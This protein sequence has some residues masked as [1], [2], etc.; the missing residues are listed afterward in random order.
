MILCAVFYTDVIYKMAKMQ[1][2]AEKSSMFKGLG[3]ALTAKIYLDQDGIFKNAMQNLYLFI[4]LLTMGI[5]SRE[6]NTGSI[7]LLYS[8]PIKTRDIV[9]GKY[10]SLMLFNLILVSVIGIFMVVGLFSVKSV[11]V[12][13]LLSA[14]LGFYLLVC[15]YAA[16]G[17]F[18]SSLTTY[19]IVSAIGTFII[20]FILSRIGNLWQEF[21]FVRDLTYF[22]SIN[23]RA[24]K[25][26]AGLITSKDVIYFLIVIGMF[27]GFTLIKLKSGRESG[28][29]FVTAGKYLAV[30]GIALCI[31]YF[32]SRPQMVGYWDTTMAQSN[33]IHPRVQEI[34]KGMGDDE[35]EITL[36]TN[37]FPRNV[38]HGLPKN[39]NIYLS[40]LWE[41][42]LRFKPDIKFKYEYYYA[43]NKDERNYSKSPDKSI[44]EKAKDQAKSRDLD[45]SMFKTPEQMRKIID[46]EPEDYNLVMQLKY[47]GR[48]TFLRTYNDSRVWP[49]EQ[50]IAAALARVQGQKMP[51][52]LFTTGNLERDIYV[53]GE[54]GFYGSTVGKL[55]RTSLI[56]NGFDI[57]TIS[58]DH[59]AVP[60]NYMDVAALVLADPKTKLS[61]LTIQR[62]N[63]Y[64]GA[65][66]NMMILGEP[67]KGE[68]LRP[69]LQPLG[70]QLSS[71]MLVQV[72]KNN[73]PDKVV[74]HLTKF[75]G[76]M[77]EE[78]AL[79][80]FKKGKINQLQSYSES[81]LPI[82]IIDSKNDFIKHP[83]TITD[84][85]AV[86]L[87]KGTLVKDSV[88]PVFS[89]N[90]GDIK[91]DSFVTTMALTRPIKGKEQRVF[92]AG[93]ADFLSNRY[94]GGQFF[95]RAIY[96]W[97]D[98]NKYP[99]YGPVEPPKDDEMLIGPDIART[100]KIFFVWILPV[101]LGLLGTIILIRRKRK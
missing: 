94:N 38:Q 56:N 8:A 22:L 11:D 88:P 44:E 71:G 33:T 95:G 19:Q 91:L 20:I 36:Y 5:L 92:V 76:G 47:K 73:T 26:L 50:H 58:L 86:W 49:E 65:G 27:L 93:D 7:K 21:D 62:I 79:V 39:R 77:A 60:T 46:L 53:S 45:L 37:L 17:L 80:M 69:M 24:N 96:S 68:V 43:L 101:V 66:G 55:E 3:S 64:I 70:V 89:P 28:R 52:V 12:G 4:P 34:I 23:G 75:A 82:E 9:L 10:L 29:W 90:E 2:L 51:T 41:P 78:D 54:R 14:A 98:N 84:S 97:L 87:K 57:D 63:E 81:V 30:I 31:G 72:T 35:L 99:I 13:L 42:Y 32:S 74:P 59:R 18:M 6:I 83:V 25:M 40:K 48:T 61:P 15:A 16:I 100:L 1:E 67:G 85:G